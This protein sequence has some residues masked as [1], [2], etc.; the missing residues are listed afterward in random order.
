[1]GLPFYGRT[2]ALANPQQI[3]VGSP[4]SGPGSPGPYTREGGFMGYNEICSLED[5]WNYKYSKEHEAPIISNSNQ[6]IG[7]DNVQSL[8]KKVNF[9]TANNLGGVMIWS[10]ETDDFRGK[11]GPKYPLL[12]TINNQ[13]GNSQ[14]GIDVEIE[15]PQ[16]PS[17]PFDPSSKPEQPTANDCSVDGFFVDANDCSVYYQCAGGVSYKFACS[18]GLYFDRTASACNWPELV[19]CKN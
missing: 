2:F 12:N 16:E 15:V 10:I 4:S 19:Q 11:C 17:E 8:E 18:P 7:Y 9:A 13:L 6:W 1:M 14:D 3:T 5:S